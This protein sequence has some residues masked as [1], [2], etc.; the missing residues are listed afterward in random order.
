[1]SSSDI[2]SLSVAEVTEQLVIRGQP[3]FNPLMLSALKGYKHS[4]VAW[5]PYM[6]FVNTVGEASGAERHQDSM[7]AAA[8]TGSGSVNMTLPMVSSSASRLRESR[9]LPNLARGLMWIVL[10]ADTFKYPKKQAHMLIMDNA[11][12]ADVLLAKD[13]CTSAPLRPFDFNVA[14]PEN[15]IRQ[16]STRQECL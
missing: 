11:V 2:Q 5:Q 4:S 3:N 7:L 16:H 13:R 12:M 15:S 8:R 1:M 6:E 10:D 9:R 14:D